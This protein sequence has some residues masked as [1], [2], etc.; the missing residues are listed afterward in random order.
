[1]E[2]SI[3]RPDWCKHKDCNFV[4]AFQVLGMPNG[5]CGGKKPVS[6]NHKQPGMA[7]HE[8][9]KVNDLRFC[10]KFDAPNDIVDVSCH[11]GDL[12]YFR[13]IFDCLDGKCTSWLTESMKRY[14]SHEK[15]LR[16]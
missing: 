15:G 7:P 4:R 2:M 1:M 5:I 8:G 16:I 9:I 6:S 3:K 13:Y 12:D 11:K 10:I 14:K